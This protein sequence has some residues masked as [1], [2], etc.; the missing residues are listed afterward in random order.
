MN[1]RNI[2]DIKIGAPVRRL[3]NIIAYTI[4]VLQG[5]LDVLGK[6]NAS[7]EAVTVASAIPLIITALAMSKYG[8]KKE[9]L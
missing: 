6:V 8:N 9:E 4:I 3:I 2:L 7:G 5:V 1:F